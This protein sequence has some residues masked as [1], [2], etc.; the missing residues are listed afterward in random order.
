M[1]PINR[2]NRERRARWVA[3]LALSLASLLTGCAMSIPLPSFFG[4]DS[5]GSIKP[6][7]S[8]LS[9]DMEMKDW[10][11]AQPVLA[12]ALRA[13]ASQESL[14]WTNPDTGK[15]GAF[16]GVAAS[17]P[18]KGK[19]CRAFVARF[20]LP[21]AGAAAPDQTVQATGCFGDGPEIDVSDVAPF[22]GL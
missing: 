5:T 7:A 16:L 11:V 14:A 10:Q 18:R 15:S 12:K 2:R 4:D 3:A 1:I 21:Q 19:T 9:K 13:D 22:R 17:F 6:Q 8:P 20:G